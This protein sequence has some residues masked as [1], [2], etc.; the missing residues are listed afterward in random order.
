MGAISDITHAESCGH[1]A[2][3]TV[4]CSDAMERDDKL[5][6]HVYFIP[7]RSLDYHYLALGFACRP[8]KRVT[9]NM[10]IGHP[11]VPQKAFS[12]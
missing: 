4:Y 1:C 6:S 9:T 3:I 11:I 5:L 12:I 7:W 8:Q 2:K 10:C